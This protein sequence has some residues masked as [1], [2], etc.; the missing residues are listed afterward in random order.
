MPDISRFIHEDAAYDDFGDFPGPAGPVNYIR[1]IIE[2]DLPP[3]EENGPDGWIAID[4]L[5]ETDPD[6]LAIVLAGADTAVAMQGLIDGALT[7]AAG[8]MAGIGERILLIEGPDDGLSPSA[9]IDA[10]AQTMRTS[11]N[12]RRAK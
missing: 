10:L 3:V 9:V 2:A 8:D 1:K 6:D 12:R 5:A 4:S 11:A 7:V